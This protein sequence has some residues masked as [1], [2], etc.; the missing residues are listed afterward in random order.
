VT[1]DIYTRA[2]AFVKRIHQVVNTG[3]SRN[4]QLNWAGDNQAG[5]KLA[6]GVYIYR[7][8]VVAGDQRTESTQQLIIF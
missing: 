4:C 3:G 6:K 7:V 1:V 5:A 8:I 2:G